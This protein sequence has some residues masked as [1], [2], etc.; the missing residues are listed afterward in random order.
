MHWFFCINLKLYLVKG[1]VR[2][3][4]TAEATWS[5][6]IST[7]HSAATMAILSLKISIVDS[8]V[9]K[10]MQFDPSMPAFDACH[11]ILQKLA[12]NVQRDR[13]LPVFSWHSSNHCTALDLLR[14]DGWPWRMYARVQHARVTFGYSIFIFLPKTAY[15][16]ATIFHFCSH[17]NFSGYFA[18]WNFYS[19]YISSAAF[20]NNGDHWHKV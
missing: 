11:L 13:E 3:R 14:L 5:E 1:V 12:D 2:W 7:N 19:L 9:V 16:R 17:Q 18:H 20:I 8:C 10:T 15:N 6:P 4:E